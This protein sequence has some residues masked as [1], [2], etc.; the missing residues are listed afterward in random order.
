MPLS[1]DGMGRKENLRATG[2]P[3]ACATV[4]RWAPSRVTRRGALTATAAA[5]AAAAIF[6]SPPPLSLLLG[7][8]PRLTASTRSLLPVPV[9]LLVP[10]GPLH[11]HHGAHGRVA[12]SLL[13]Y[14]IHLRCSVYFQMPQRMLSSSF[15]YPF[16]LSLSSSFAALREPRA[17][18][19]PSCESN[20]YMYI[21]S[22]FSGL[23]VDPSF[24]VDTCQA[25][26]PIF[27]FLSFF[28][29]T[30]PAISPIPESK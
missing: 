12:A 25:R 2:A 13:R 9:A 29:S 5:A 19:R 8:P 22:R 7:C 23:A 15:F 16:S 24:R 6:P 1:P 28:L 20:I 26:S 3:V 4:L 17:P 14:E 30:A 11:P 10:R 27:F 18:N 21:Y